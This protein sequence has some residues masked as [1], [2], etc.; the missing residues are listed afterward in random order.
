VGQLDGDPGA[1]ASLLAMMKQ[2]HRRIDRRRPASRFNKCAPSG[3]ENWAGR[4]RFRILCARLSDV[5][6]K[7]ESY[8]PWPV[9]GGH[10]KD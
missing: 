1:A 4:Y 2:S 8:T 3:H 9:F 6:K 10:E 7:S 5:A